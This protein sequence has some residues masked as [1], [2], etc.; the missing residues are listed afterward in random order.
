MEAR[1]LIKERISE[2]K[3]K[4]L[5]GRLT[6][7]EIVELGKLYITDEN[8]DIYE[9]KAEILNHHYWKTRCLLFEKFI[10]T[11]TIE[12]NDKK[13]STIKA[14]EEYENFLKTNKEPGL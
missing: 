1:N 9:K 14:K 13:L 8:N 11:V 6:H 2:L 5:T 10:S 12:I 7:N 4:E 3:E